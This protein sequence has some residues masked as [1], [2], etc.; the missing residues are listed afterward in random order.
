MGT[1]I[2]ILSG[3]RGYFYGVKRSQPESNH[4]PPLSDVF[5]TKVALHLH[6]GTWGGVVVKALRY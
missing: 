3:H 2:F 4:S 5:Q 6:S 1:L